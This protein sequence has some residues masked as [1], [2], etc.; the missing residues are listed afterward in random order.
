[1]R[2]VVVFALLLLTAGSALAAP[3]PFP[4]YRPDRTSDLVWIQG[5]WTRT[6]VYGWRADGWESLIAPPHDFTFTDRQLI[7]GALIERFALHP[8][9]SP[10][11]IDFSSN[12]VPG[13]ERGVY[14]IE[15]DTLT[16]V[17]AP[18]GD[19]RPRSLDDGATKYVFRRKR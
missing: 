3:A 12:G 11:G 7:V 15:G 13:V 18:R 19:K 6:A 9:Q 17:L 10:R 1:M 5:T 14:T 4:K 16:I 2:P 8:Y